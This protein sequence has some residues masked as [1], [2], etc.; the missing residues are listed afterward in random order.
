MVTSDK[1][2][3]FGYSTTQPTDKINGV[4]NIK[5]YVPLLLD[6]NQLNYDVQKELFKTYCL[7]YNVQDH[8][9]DSNKLPDDIEWVT[10]DNI[11]KQW[12]YGSFTQTILQSIITIDATAADVWKSIEDLFHENKVIKAI[13]LDDE[14]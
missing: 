6:M 1:E 4:T 7:R 10:V 13:E 5:L 2:K 3:G 9:D 11:I 14:L 12:L 8:L